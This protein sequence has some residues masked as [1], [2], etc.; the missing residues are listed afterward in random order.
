MSIAKVII[1]VS[2]M[3]GVSI[4]LYFFLLSRKRQPRI[5]LSISRL[6]AIDE[7]TCQDILKTDGGRIFGVPNYFVGIVYYAS[8]ILIALRTEWL[9][10]HLFTLMIF[11]GLSVLTSLYLAHLLIIKLEAKCYFCFFI[12]SLNIILFATI[13]TIYL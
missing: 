8:L 11:S 2:S 5:I 1:L 9:E 10:D 4:S 3:I 12:H 13:L 7:Q 6:C